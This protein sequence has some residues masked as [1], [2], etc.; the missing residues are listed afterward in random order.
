MLILFIMNILVIFSLISSPLRGADSP[1]NPA[2]LIDA[3]N[4]FG[5]ALFEQLTTGQMDENV[6]I[7]P[8]SIASALT[9]CLNGAAGETRTAMLKTLGLTGLELDAVNTQAKQL[10]DRLSQTES[11]VILKIAN[12]LW[13]RK[14]VVFKSS[15]K[16]KIQRFHAAEMFTLDFN[17]ADAADVINRWVTQKTQNKI[18]SIITR[19]N[20]EQVLFLIN[21]IYFKGKWQHPF[22]K[23]MTADE[24]FYLANDKTI[25]VPMM[26]RSGKFN[27][28]ETD[29][30]A[31][32][33]LPY[34]QGNISMFLLLPD[35][36]IG[37]KGLLAR[38]NPDNWSTWLAL[39]ES[40]QG[41]IALPRFKIEY[42]QSLKPALS[43][44]G[45][46]LAFDL[47][48]ANFS[49]MSSVPLAVGDVK[50]KSYLEVNEEGTEAAA[51]TSV[52][53][54][55]TAVPARTFNL[56]FNRPFVFLLQDNHTGAILFLGTVCQP[57]S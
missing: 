25:R 55:M 16:K 18:R 35:E 47:N 6:V 43:K 7:S 4:Q 21:A 41:Q 48:R 22:D 20:P 12:S 13:A 30:F 39:F 10:R 31:A 38:F 27:Y 50:H 11:G 15:F 37:I 28:L 40:R 5:F 2:L 57:G 34:A 32:V 9:M 17:R 1:S 26:H 44:L 52:E 54:V 36:S 3:S 53:M 56:F 29:G 49:E 42:E 14:E 8:Y 24:E 23:E 45:M 46:A 33:E 51:V 19:I